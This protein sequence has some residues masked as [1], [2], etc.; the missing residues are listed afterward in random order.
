MYSLK[1]RNYGLYLPQNKRDCKWFQFVA[2][3]FFLPSVTRQS[4]RFL[5]TLKL[6]IPQLI[7]N[8]SAP[9]LASTPTVRGHAEACPSTTYTEICVSAVAARC[10]DFHSIKYVARVGRVPGA[11]LCFRFSYSKFTPQLSPIS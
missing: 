8:V 2:E 9:L 7:S 4:E 5:L 11:L 10:R 6:S 1:V 3:N